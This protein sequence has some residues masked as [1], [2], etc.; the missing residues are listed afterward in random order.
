MQS[1]CDYE[2]ENDL[3]NALYSSLNLERFLH[4]C[5]RL[6]NKHMPVS[7]IAIF[8]YDIKKKSLS[9]L[10]E[11][12]NGHAKHMAPYVELPEDIIQRVI[13]I[14]NSKHTTKQTLVHMDMH[15][16]A[17]LHIIQK[18]VRG[19]ISSNI[20]LH[21]YLEGD[22][23]YIACIY[24]FGE[25][26]YSEEHLRISTI[27][28]EPL[29]H[30]VELG[31]QNKTL[32]HLPATSDP[33]LARSQMEAF[34]N[35]P[36]PGMR[37]VLQLV[38]RAATTDVPVLILGETGV[39]KEIVANAIQTLSDRAQ[40]PFVKVN[41]GAIPETLIDSELFGH[42][43]GAFTGALTTKIGKFE[44]ASG[45]VIFL[46][47]IGELSQAL[48]VRLLRVLQFKE[49][50]R[51][52][53]SKP[54]RLDIRI[55]AA[56]HRNLKKM[57]EQGEFREDL[58]FRLNIFPISI[59][60]LRQRKEDIEPLARLL[61]E[62]RCTEMKME[63]VPKFS[64]TTLARFNAYS[65]PGNV[66]ELENWIWR[67]CITQQ[68]SD[69][70]ECMPLVD[71]EF[72]TPDY[73]L[74]QEDFMTLDAMNALYISRILQYTKGRIHGKYGAAKILGINPSTLRSRIEKLG[75]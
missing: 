27:I 31:V 64:Q 70:L 20:R 71:E 75:L 38:R 32:M 44:R 73:A 60:P 25:N 45:G 26:K 37:P 19:A 22:V 2:L 46:D 52:G 29:A 24:A 16:I 65:W 36:T 56:T 13:N 59:L 17:D 28:R 3:E 11:A 69:T 47:E 23:Y 50:E 1:Q 18:L 55:I 41:C 40:K 5:I 62:Q 74:A 57:V 43:R 54:V 51:V 67:S 49:I 39:G 34:L 15:N 58:W 33:R 9:L 53:G 66:R 63:R 12:L 48:Q 30:V 7:G 10:I 6:L 8:S 68:H 14:E 4:Y 21:L 61:L 42:E 72:P 35:S